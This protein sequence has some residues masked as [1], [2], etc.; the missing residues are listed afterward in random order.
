MEWQEGGSTSDMQ[1]LDLLLNDRCGGITKTSYGDA[2]AISLGV[3][4]YEVRAGPGI[5]TAAGDLSWIK[6]VAPVVAG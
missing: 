3:G 1:E 2:E 4:L 5:E 6:Q